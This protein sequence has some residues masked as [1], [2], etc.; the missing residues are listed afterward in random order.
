MN[1]LKTDTIVFSCHHSIFS[2]C[3]SFHFVKKFLDAIKTK[4]F[5]HSSDK[6]CE[7]YGSKEYELLQFLYLAR[8]SKYS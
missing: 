8:F 4:K 6:E 1:L 5:A 3:W 2:D 7:M